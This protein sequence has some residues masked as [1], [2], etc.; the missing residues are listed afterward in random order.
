MSP[1]LGIFWLPKS[2]NKRR[3]WLL[4]LNDAITREDMFNHR[5]EQVVSFTLNIENRDLKSK[6][7][8]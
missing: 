8:H 5:V 4:I 2:T 1:T 7:E 3:D 6:S